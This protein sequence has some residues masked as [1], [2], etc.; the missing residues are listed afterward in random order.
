M[1]PAKPD[2]F[3]SCGFE[4]GLSSEQWSPECLSPGVTIR[5]PSSQQSNVPV[6][7]L[8]TS[9]VSIHQKHDPYPAGSKDECIIETV[10]Q[11]GGHRKPRMLLLFSRA[12]HRKPGSECTGNSNWRI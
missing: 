9:M 1:A 8:L 6:Q 4:E 7:L 11:N 5:P 3:S 10:E 2:M 12:A